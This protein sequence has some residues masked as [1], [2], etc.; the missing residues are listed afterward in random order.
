AFAGLNLPALDAGLAW[1]TSRL[2]VD[3]NLRVV[4]GT[5]PLTIAAQPL[6]QTANVGTI[7]KLLGGAVGTGPISYHWQFNGSDLTGQTGPSLTLPNIQKTNQG[8]YLFIASNSVGSVTSTVAIL[9]VNR[10]P[11]AQG[12]SVSVPW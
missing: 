1:D 6:T 3:G 11:I 10:A 8:S 2:I 4:S 7:V 5:I 9:T 12:Q